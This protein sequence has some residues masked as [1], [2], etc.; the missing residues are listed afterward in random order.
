LQEEE[1]RIRRSIAETGQYQEF[2]TV[3]FV[4]GGSQIA[5][6]VQLVPILDRYSRTRGIS[7]ASTLLD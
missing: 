7:Q 4:R 1:Q 3:R 6:N 5:V 2:R